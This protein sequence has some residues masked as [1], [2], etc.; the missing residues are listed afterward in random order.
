L[1]VES[2]VVRSFDRDL[3]EHIADPAMYLSLNGHLHNLGIKY[4]EGKST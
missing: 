4:K 1:T 3:V 2:T